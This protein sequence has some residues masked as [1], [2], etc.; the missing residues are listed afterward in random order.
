LL[1][2]DRAANQNARREI[3]FAELV[4]LDHRA[5]APSSTNSFAGGG[6]K[7]RAGFVSVKPSRQAASCSAGR[8][9][10]MA[11]RIDRSARF[12]V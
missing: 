9:Q 1:P 2:R 11:D 8:S 6:L 5:M 12:I 10:K 7:E 4:L 3:Q